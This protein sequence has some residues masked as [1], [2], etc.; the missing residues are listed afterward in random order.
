VVCNPSR[1]NSLSTST[2][3]SAIVISLD[4]SLFWVTM[5]SSLVFVTRRSVSVTRRSVS[6]TRRSVS[7]TRSSLAAPFLSSC[8]LALPLEQRVGVPQG[9]VPN[10]SR[11][12]L[13][14]TPQQPRWQMLVDAHERFE[15]AALNVQPSN[16]DQ[17]CINQY[18]IAKKP[19]GPGFI[20]TKE[21]TTKGLKDT[22]CSKLTKSY[23][24]NVGC[25]L[26]LQGHRPQTSQE[27]RQLLYQ[28]HSGNVLSKVSLSSQ[29]R[30]QLQT[31]SR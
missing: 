4:T 23:P 25:L 11:A 18:K 29:D 10:D 28:H 8:L 12:G 17:A 16:A 2:R 26:S 9:D 5:T 1:F 15:Q 14:E 19:K 22:S 21:L 24:D 20:Q 31:S 27:E 7:A 13:L 3:L 6:V 30:Q